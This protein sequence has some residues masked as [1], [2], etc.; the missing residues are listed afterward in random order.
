[1]NNNYL[2]HNILVQTLTTHDS[3]IVL[4]VQQSEKGV[5]GGGGRGFG[6]VHI[7]LDSTLPFYFSASRRNPYNAGKRL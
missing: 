3:D 1:M 2:A 4:I 7:I 5:E 6:I